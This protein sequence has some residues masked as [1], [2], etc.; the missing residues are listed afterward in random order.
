MYKFFMV[1]AS[2]GGI[3]QLIVG[4]DSIAQTPPK[5]DSD[6]AMVNSSGKV[7]DLSALCGATPATPTQSKPVKPQSS[8]E[9]VTPGL[10]RAKIKYRRGGT[11]VIDVA[12]SSSRG[13]QLMEM[14][15][16]TGAS[17]TAITEAMAKSLGVVP[18][19]KVTVS[20]ATRDDEEIHVGLISLI[21][22]NGI[23][24]RNLPVG[25]LP[26]K[27]LGLL[28]QDFYGKFDITVKKDVIEF[29]LPQ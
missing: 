29:R 15:V 27:G 14:L 25:I 2:I 16:D 26:I 13:M 28:G 24:K 3:A 6:C 9:P 20:T 11:P 8:I 19:A 23:R 17:G 1:L 21:E 10:V 22:V 5:L 4:G 18:L 12:F 7:I